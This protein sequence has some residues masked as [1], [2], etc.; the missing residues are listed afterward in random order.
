MPGTAVPAQARHDAGIRR[1]GGSSAGGGRA[2]APGGMGDAIFRTLQ[3]NTFLTPAEVLG[4]RATVSY[5]HP[6]PIAKFCGPRGVT[7]GGPPVQSIS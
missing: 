5:H 1:A 7:D 2:S 3:V 4:L 6:A